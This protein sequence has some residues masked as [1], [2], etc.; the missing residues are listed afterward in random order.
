MAKTT[1][2][3]TR[4][5]VNCAPGDFPQHI[6]DLITAER[7]VYDK[8]KEARK[9]TAAAINAVIS[10]PAGRHV[11]ATAFTRWGQM[12]LIVDDVPSAKPKAEK[13]GRMSLSDYL[14]STST[15]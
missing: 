1:K 9:A 3:D 14:A 2:T 12:Q 6:Q 11:A 15:R 4:E 13:S 7:K 10:L 8:L 5:Y